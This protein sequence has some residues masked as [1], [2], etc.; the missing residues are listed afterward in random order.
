[1]IAE[2]KRALRRLAMIV[3]AAT[4]LA[5]LGLAALAVSALG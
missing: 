5:A 4:V 2:N 1:V 3:N